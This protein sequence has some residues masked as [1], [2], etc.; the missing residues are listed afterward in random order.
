MAKANLKLGKKQIIIAFAAF[1]GLLAALFIGQGFLQKEDRGLFPSLADSSFALITHEG[2][3][4]TNDDL[5]GK[6]T[7][8]YFGFTWCPDICPTTLSL[9]ADIKAELQSQSIAGAEA[10]Q[11]VFFTVDPDRDTAH[12]MN[13]YL[14]LFDADIIGITG[15]TDEIQESLRRF[16]IYAERVDT[17]DEDYLIDH[18][19]S[20]YLYQSN[21]QFKGTIS[22][23][24]PYEMAL[25]KLQRLIAL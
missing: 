6:P 3:A 10:L 18:S 25:A 7:A 8:I 23:A 9:M 14:S 11:L 12:Q 13:E 22:P 20:V 24:E 1:V 15:K 17:S 2:K 4:I 19:A 16:G 21:G 5:I